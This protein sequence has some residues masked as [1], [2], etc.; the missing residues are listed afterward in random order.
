[1]QIN[2]LII[3]KISLSLYNENYL[4]V[5]EVFLCR[6]SYLF[7]DNW[8]L[9]LDNGLFLFWEVFK[10]TFKWAFLVSDKGR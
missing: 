4:R 8:L 3:D 7:K 2:I 9:A 10:L 5:K 1:V 6:K